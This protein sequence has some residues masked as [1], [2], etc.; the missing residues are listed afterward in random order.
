[1]KILINDNKKHPF[2]IKNMSAKN[3]REKYKKCMR[4]RKSL[5]KQG[6]LKGTLCDVGYCTAVSKFK[7]Y[8]S[9]YANLSA[10]KVCKRRSTKSSKRKSSRKSSNSL[11]R[12]QREKWVDVCTRDSRGRHPPCSNKRSKRYPYCRPSKKISSK[13]PVT[14]SELTPSQKKR[15][16]SRK[17]K[18]PQK[19]MRSLKRKR[20]HGRRR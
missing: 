19:K 14:A 10:A 1:M 12:W 17:R 16:C 20:S 9:A 3:E 13:T 15:L 11:N 8:P 4:K 18:Q 6:K 5:K 7:K 2:P